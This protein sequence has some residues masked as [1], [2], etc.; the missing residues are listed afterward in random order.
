MRVGL[1]RP[2]AVGRSRD[3]GAASFG[4]APGR[5]PDARKDERILPTH[6]VSLPQGLGRHARLETTGQALVHNLPTGGD[7]FLRRRE[8]AELVALVFVHEVPVVVNED[9]VTHLVPFSSDVVIGGYGPF[10][11]ENELSFQFLLPPFRAGRHDQARPPRP[12]VSSTTARSS[13]CHQRN[14]GE[15]ST[16]NIGTSAGSASAQWI[17]PAQHCQG[18]LNR[19][20]I[21]LRRLTCRSRLG[22]S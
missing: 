9:L 21:P 15:P 10:E 12:A 16:L 14:V 22:G 2:R 17:S 18:C 7:R 1:W 11:V 4:I 8:G 6:L 20:A 13:Q 5:E 3:L 19:L